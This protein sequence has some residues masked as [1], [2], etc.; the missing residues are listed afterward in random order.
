MS[1]QRGK[2]T[3]AIISLLFGVPILGFAAL[4]VKWS[5]A[6]GPVTALYRM[7][8]GAV[9]ITP[10]FLARGKTPF[11]KLSRRGVLVALV[12]GALFGTDMA[13][14]MTAV[15]MSGATMPTLM[16]NTA[17]LW[18]GIG[19]VLLFKERQS[20]GFRVGLALA[21]VGVVL[22]FGRNLQ[23]GAGP[24][25]GMALGLV[26]AL[27]YAAF[28]LAT[29]EG[30]RHLNTVTYLY[31]STLG[32]AGA[33]LVIN[34]I[35]RNRLTG[36]D[37]QT[38]LSFLALGVAVQFLGWLLINFSQGYLRASVVAPVLLLQPVLTALLAIPLLGENLTPYHVAGGLTVLS[39]IYIVIWSRNRALRA[40]ADAAPESSAARRPER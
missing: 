24:V 39:G 38:Y 19:S 14:W 36:F 15:G 30:R 5:G 1:L 3:L 6:P 27:F 35:M 22:V 40:A 13:I 21:I 28:V 4:F 32:A 33:L 17:P 29:Q 18:V 20:R 11:H 31:I 7:L 25:R 12:G 37:R 10:L 34:L 23:D 2:R 26:A 16:A 9:V 8:I